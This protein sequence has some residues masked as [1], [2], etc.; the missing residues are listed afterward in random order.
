MR[1]LGLCGEYFF[2]VNPE[3]PY[4]KTSSAILLPFAQ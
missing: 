3:E 1:T 2:T 4:L